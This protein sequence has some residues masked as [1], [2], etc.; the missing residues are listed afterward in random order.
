MYSFCQYSAHIMNIFVFNSTLIIGH[1]QWW[2][3]YGLLPVKFLGQFLSHNGSS[4]NVSEWLPDYCYG[5]WEMQDGV[6]S[7]RQSWLSKLLYS[8]EQQNV[9]RDLK[10]FRST[11]PILSKTD[12]KNCMYLSGRGFPPVLISV[13]FVSFKVKMP[14]LALWCG[15]HCTYRWT[16]MCQFLSCICLAKQSMG[17][18]IRK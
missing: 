16:E 11:L 7:K 3:S 14:V 13:C 10:V 9:E 5:S 12:W 17:S 15:T 1:L 18:F 2:W 4:I 8:D 6:G